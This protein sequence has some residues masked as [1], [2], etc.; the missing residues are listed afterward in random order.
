MLPACTDEVYGTGYCGVYDKQG[1]DERVCHALRSSRSDAELPREPARL[2]GEVDTCF[3]NA[4]EV[5]AHSRV[6]GLRTTKVSNSLPSYVPM[7]R[8]R[9]EIAWER[10]G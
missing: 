3:V 1:G 10:V 9:G 2:M 8:R 4:P 5:H 7:R 6:A